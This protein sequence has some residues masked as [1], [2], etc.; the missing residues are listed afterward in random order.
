MHFQ[1]GGCE[2]S[3]WSRIGAGWPNACFP[4]EVAGPFSERTRAATSVIGRVD[5]EVGAVAVGG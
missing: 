4:G 3:V 2:E 1:S 5:G